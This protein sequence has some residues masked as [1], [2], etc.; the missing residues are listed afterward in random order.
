MRTTDAPVERALAIDPIETPVWA[1]AERLETYCTEALRATEALRDRLAAGQAGSQTLQTFDTM[2]VLL[3]RAGNLAALM[4]QVHPD[5]AVRKAGR[6][7]QQEVERLQNDIFLDPRLYRAVAAVDTSGLDPQAARFA[8]LLLRDFRRS[9]VDKDEAT[10][11]ELRKMHAR[12]VELAQRYQQNLRSDVRS[13]RIPPARLAGLPQDYVDAHPPGDDGLVTITTDYPDFIPFETYADDA[14]A[15]QQ[16]YEEM[17][18]RG[19]PDNRDILLE[20]LQLRDRY[21]KMLGYANWADYY[22]EDKMAHDAATVA[23]FTAQIAAIARPRMESDLAAMLARKQQDDPQAKTVALWDRFYYVNKLRRERFGVDS[24]QVRRYFPYDAVRDGILAFFGEMFGLRFERVPD[25]PVW[26]PDVEAYDV[27]VDDRRAGR[28]YLD[29]HPREGKYKHAAMFP[30]VTGIEGGAEP[31]GALVCNFPKPHDDDPALMEHE[32]VVTFFHEFGHLLHHVLSTHTRWVTLTAMGV[33]WDF[34][35]VPSQLLEEWAWRPDVLQR[36]A[37]SVD[38]GEPIDAELVRRMRQA[39][40]FGKG[41]HV[42]RQIFY[43]AL[44]H[45][46]HVRDPAHLDLDAVTEELTR[47]YSPYP[48]PPRGH[49]Y[50][51]FGHLIGYT[52]GYYT[53]QWSLAIA[54]DIYRKFEQAG[55]AE[56]EVARAYRRTILEGGATK[57][58]ADLVADF[59]G[60][61]YT[62]DAYR[63]W[64]AH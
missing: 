61:P 50:A 28:I 32:D 44:S 13:I 3:D 36:F 17:L 55:D 1:G 10:R 26:H 30:I 11:D 45:E 52:S 49:V 63:D 56:P 2:L 6:R 43:T 59:L 5:E 22:A 14:A 54:K 38:T 29:M 42:M 12:M 19:W 9:G 41:V 27:W 58:A 60:R 57:D 21:A 16:L 18:L 62:L 24:Q 37:R 20:L 64:L 7:C 8:R 34:V 47:R 33:E 46:L 15:R 23:R 31:A 4:F 53:Y 39:E 48:P 40:E 51:N 35:E 25:A